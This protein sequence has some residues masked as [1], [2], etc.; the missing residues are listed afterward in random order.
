MIETNSET[1]LE[2][3]VWTARYDYD[4]DHHHHHHKIFVYLKFYSSLWNP[5]LFF[6][7]QKFLNDLFTYWYK[8]IDLDYG[9]DDI[10]LFTPV[11]HSYYS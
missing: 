2:K 6:Y 3:S 9:Q 7:E 10:L 5:F 1:E 11:K 8:F 4:G